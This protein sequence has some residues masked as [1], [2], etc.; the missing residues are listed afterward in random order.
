[1]ALTS[2][3]DL[4]FLALLIAANGVPVLAAHAVPRPVA[5]P[6]DFGL[7]LPDG[8]PLFG[9][10]KTWR[11]L[12]AGVLAAG[13]IGAAGPLGAMAGIACGALSLYGDLMTSFLKRRFALPSGA[14]LPLLDQ[15]AEATLPL[16][17]VTRF[18]PDKWRPALVASCVF[19]LIAALTDFV[20]AIR[21]TA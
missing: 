9:S 20:R 14:R 7:R 13:V 6:V 5:V 15:L 11:G 2:L 12:A 17:A 18:E 16:F 8:R 4:P 21:R 19:M 3:V 10:H 1:M